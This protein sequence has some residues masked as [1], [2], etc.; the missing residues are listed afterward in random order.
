[1]ALSQSGASLTG[2]WSAGSGGSGSVSGTVSGYGA[3]FR[4]NQTTSGCSGRFD[5]YAVVVPIFGDL[6]FW[7]SGQDCLGPHVD[8]F[9]FGVRVP[10][11]A[12]LGRPGLELARAARP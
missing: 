5:G 3:T 12:S 1:M 9:G 4:L 8:G 7:Y 6:V 2:T 11:S 10:L